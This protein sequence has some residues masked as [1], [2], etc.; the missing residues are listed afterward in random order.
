MTCLWH[1]RMPWA[2]AV[3]RACR[4]LPV[5][6]RLQGFVR[7]R[8]PGHGD[9][10]CPGA[11]SDVCAP[12]ALIEGLFTLVCGNPGHFRPF[13]GFGGGCAGFAAFDI[14]CGL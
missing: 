4:W 1:P 11:Q 5:V 6:P 12:L 14:L 2:H 8:G 7:R 9:R 10:H 3:L 13:A